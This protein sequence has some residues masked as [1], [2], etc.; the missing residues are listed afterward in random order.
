MVMACATS[1]GST[2]LDLVVIVNQIGGGL[3]ICIVANHE[4]LR[5]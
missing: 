1:A 5:A 4:D 3:V 2:T